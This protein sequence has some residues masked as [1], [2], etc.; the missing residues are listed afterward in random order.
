[1]VRF[2]HSSWPKVPGC[3][4]IVVLDPIEH[5]EKTRQPAARYR[6]S[7]YRQPFFFVFT[8]LV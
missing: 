6:G 5:G 3:C 2:R 8:G 1:M 4:P 7:L